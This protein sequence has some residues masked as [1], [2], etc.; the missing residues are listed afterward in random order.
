MPG[1]SELLIAAYDRGPICFADD[2][3][4]DQ[5]DLSLYRVWNRK[6]LSAGMITPFRRSLKRH[7]K[8]AKNSPSFRSCHIFNAL[9]ANYTF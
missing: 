8:F 4:S 3:L 9:P 7:R 6:R 5:I 2:S 1:F